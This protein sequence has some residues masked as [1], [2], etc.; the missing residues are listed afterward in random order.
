MCLAVPGKVIEIFE[1]AGLKM[2]KID[3]AGTVNRVCLEFVTDIKVG[4]YAV[5]HAGFALSILDEEEA[6]KTY[7]AWEELIGHSA[8]QNQE[9][10]A[11]QLNT[12][13]NLK[14]NID[15]KN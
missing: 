12:I 13:R 1:E 10:S 11:D 9:H 8:S 7:D 3:Y 14:N 5:V 15:R 2:G 4:Q 6:A